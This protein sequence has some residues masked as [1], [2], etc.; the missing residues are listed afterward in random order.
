M[1]SYA[2]YTLNSYVAYSLVEKKKKTASSFFE[3]Y[4][5]ELLP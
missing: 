1:A 2:R 3:K 4:K 5:S